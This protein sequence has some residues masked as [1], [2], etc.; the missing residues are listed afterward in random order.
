M[1][2]KV[3][4]E[5]IVNGKLSTIEQIIA[6][7]DKNL[8]RLDAE[9][10]K[11]CEQLTRSLKNCPLAHRQPNETNGE[12]YGCVPC[13]PDCRLVDVR[14]VTGTYAPSLL[15][16][17]QTYGAGGYDVVCVPCT[18]KNGETT[19]FRFYDGRCWMSSAT[20]EN[21]FRISEED[22]KDIMKSLQSI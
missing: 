7:C 15:V 16:K 6:E 12:R 17:G 8:A 9:E 11:R 22:Y 3:E 20:P 19:Q 4:V 18:L 2:G 21:Y 5:V 1:E 13:C 10:K 14:I